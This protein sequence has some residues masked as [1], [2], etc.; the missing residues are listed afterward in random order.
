MNIV[1]AGAGKVGFN[2]AKALS[3]IHNVTIIDKN[4]EAL[5]SIQENLDILTIRG[6]LE[7]ITT[8]SKCSDKNI[9]LFIAVTDIDNVNLVSIMMADSI[10]NISRRFI[11]LQKTFFSKDVLK[12]KFNIDEVILPQKLASE[13]IASLLYYPQANNVKFFNYTDYRLMSIRLSEN[14]TVCSVSSDAFIIVGIERDKVFFIPKEDDYIQANDLVY[15]FGLEDNIANFCSNINLSVNNNI[16]KC[17]VFGGEDLGIS[18]SKAL[19]NINRDVK[20]VEK[21]L[22]LCTKA[23][24]ELNGKATI[25]NSKYGTENIFDDEHFDSADIFIAATKNDEFNI[26]KCLEA[27]EK[28]INKV[29]AINN[30]MEYYSLMHTLGIIVARGP[31]MTAYNKIME[32]IN[33]SGV[34]IQKTFCGAKAIVYMR[35]IFQNSHLINKTIKYK[36]IKNT[37]IL[38]LRDNILIKFNKNIILQQDDVIVV[39]TLINYDDIAKKWIYE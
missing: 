23:D 4:L 29:V 32:E 7:N 39:F 12:S 8:Y 27:K 24:E 20:L 3:I 35:K 14:I 10:F 33:S 22:T 31:K 30:A 6:D 19:L 13:N 2:L 1:I 21:D 38:F 28:G 25:I 34:I 37:S 11:R 26:I 5:Y 17:V 16:Q 36:T 18:I 15:F 9:D